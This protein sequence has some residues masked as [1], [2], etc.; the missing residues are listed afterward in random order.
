MTYCMCVDTVDENEQSN[1][2]NDS[3]HH[4]TKRW[5][6]E[7]KKERIKKKERRNNIR[8]DNPRQRDDI[9]MM[10]TILEFSSTAQYS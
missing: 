8:E 5:K 3:G 2:L 7:N 10:L 9:M 4:W 1:E 6:K